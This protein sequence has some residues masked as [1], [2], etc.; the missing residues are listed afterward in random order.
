MKHEVTCMDCGK[1]E[2]IEVYHGQP[3]K[4]GWVYYGKLNV[5]TCE[6]SKYFLRPKD[7]TKIFENCERIPNNCYDPTVKPK[8]VEMW[9]CPQCVSQLKE[10]DVKK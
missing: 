5:N 6:T 4:S 8:Y 9:T 10:K 1:T 2:H 7:Q 3:I